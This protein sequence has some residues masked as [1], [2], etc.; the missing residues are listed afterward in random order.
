MNPPTAS[1]RGRSPLFLAVAGCVLVPLSCLAVVMCLVLA[2][3]ANAAYWSS[4]RRTAI[5][6]RGSAAGAEA[7]PAA[8]TLLAEWEAL[9]AG[10]ASAGE[11]VFN[12]EGSCH[13]CHS[14]EPQQQTVGPSLSGLGARAGSARP[15][16]SAELYLYES[17]VYPNAHV[18]AGFHGNV[19]PA[20]FKQR[21]SDQQLADLVAYLL[22]R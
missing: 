18:V 3:V 10:D 5:T 20:G 7:L 21:L 8:D 13:A 12:G 15:D 22:T 2:G 19:M 6:E 14:L 16:Y 1:S 17:I 11:Q 9:P 4:A